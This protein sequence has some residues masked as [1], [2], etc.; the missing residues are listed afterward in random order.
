MKARTPEENAQHQRD[1][2]AKRKPVVG[3]DLA[4]GKDATA[5]V[6]IEDGR[7]TVKEYKGV[8][9]YHYLPGDDV[10]SKLTQH[11]RD[12]IMAKLPKTSTRTR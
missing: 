11:Q 12:V 1:L 7:A 2:R 3:V 5:V 6:V 8:S 10:I 4:K 9:G